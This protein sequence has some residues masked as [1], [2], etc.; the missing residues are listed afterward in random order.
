MT[1]CVS[2]KMMLSHLGQPAVGYRFVIRLPAGVT[3]QK[4][5]R[6][7]LMA[8]RVSAGDKGVQTFQSMHLSVSVN[9]SAR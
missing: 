9:G 5:R 2:V 7:L 6:G 1:A 8:M 4:H 3:N